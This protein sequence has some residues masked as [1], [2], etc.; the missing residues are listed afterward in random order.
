MCYSLFRIYPKSMSPKG[1]NGKRSIPQNILTYLQ[2][3]TYMNE[4]I[5]Q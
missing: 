5:K 3:L 1:Q 2:F 4:L